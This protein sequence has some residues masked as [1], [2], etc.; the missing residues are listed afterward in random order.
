LT[1]VACLPQPVSGVFGDCIVAEY[2]TATW[3]H[4]CPFAHEALK[5]IYAGQWHPFYY[6]SLVCDVNTHAD[7]RANELGLGGYPTVYFDGGY[8]SVVGG[9]EVF[10]LHITQVLSTVV[11]GTFL[12]LI[13]IFLLL[14]M[15]MQIW[16]YMCLLIIMKIAPIV[17][18]FMYM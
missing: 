15:E 8:K 7:A 9:Y 14:G 1:A 4:Y 13:W 17:G 16:I 5:N 2:G 3:C 11:K 10:N 18:T 12:I 6:V